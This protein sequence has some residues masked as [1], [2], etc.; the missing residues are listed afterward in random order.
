[1][2]PPPSA[3][4]GPSNAPQQQQGPAPPAAP[5]VGKT[6]GIYVPPFKLARMMNHVEDK[7][8][9]EY[10]RQ[11]WEAL[12]KSINGII[13]KVNSTNIKAILLEIFRENLVRGRGLF[14][15]SIMK[16]QLASPSFSP[17]FASLVAVVNTKFPEIGEL[18]LGRLVLQFKRSYRR[19]DKPVCSAASKFI[20]HLINQGVAHEVLA[21]EMLLLMLEHPSNDS[22]EMA[23]DFTK[24][25]GA[26]LS[27][28][29][30]AGLGSVFERFR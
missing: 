1:M 17:V 8:S 6:G 15:R 10:Q 3:E 24:E 18:L 14:C 7:S 5:K 11:T 25:V 9:P 2:G 29:V 26:Y 12:K 27:D 28:V 19:N 4:A 20:A 16:S 30:P 22:V 23:V 21:L 13:N